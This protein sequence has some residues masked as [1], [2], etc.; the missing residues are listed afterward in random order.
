[1]API[2]IAD[3]HQTFP[4]S[5][6][7]LERLS[8]T[9]EFDYPDPYNARELNIRLRPPLPPYTPA[10]IIAVGLIGRIYLRVID[11]H[12]D[13]SL[14]SFDSLDNALETA[15][16][17]DTADKSIELMLS[18]FPTTPAHYTPEISKEYRLTFT[19]SSAKRHSLYKSILLIFLADLNQ[20]LR[21]R[22]NLFTD[23]DLRNNP[24]YIPFRDVIFSHLSQG[25]PLGSSAKSLIDFLA[26][27]SRLHPDSLYD[28]L[29][30]IR[31]NWGAYLGEAFLLG[32]LKALDQIKEEMSRNFAG[33]SGPEDPL[34]YALASYRSETDFVR[35]SDDLDWMPKVI[36]IAKNVF[37][38]LDQLSKE[39][40]MPIHKLDQIPD[41]ELARLSSW[42]ITGLWL[43]GLWQ[44]SSA[45]QKIKQIRG[46]L[47]AVPSAYSL[48]DYAIADALGGDSAYQDLS[49]R[50][51]RY[52]IRLAADM[53]PNHMGIY[54]K[55]VV[56]HPDWFLSVDSS[57]YPGYSF[58]GPD[59]S[60]DDRVGIFLEDHYYNETD[61]AVVFRRLDRQTGSESFIYHGN[62]GTS[63]PWNDTAQLDFL[64]P[65]VREAV[66]QNILHVARKFPII[67]FDAAMTLAK[68][69]IQ[70]LWFPEPGSGGA[71]PT[72]SGFGLSRKFF[73]ELMP[74]EF[75]RE[76]VD[77]V[78]IEAPD[79]LLLAEAFWMMEGFF[80]RSLGMHRVYNSAFMHML[81]DEEND[82]YRDLIIKTLEYDP[83]ILKRY[84]NFMNNPDEDTAISQYGSDGKYF[85]VCTLMA[86]LPGLPMIGHGQIE[87]FSEKYGMEYQRAYYDEQP[88]Q[89]LIERHQREIFPLL[90]KRYLFAEV[91]DFYLFDFITDEGEINQNV[92]AYTNRSGEE[93]A[94]VVYHN[95][96]ADTSGSIQ[97]SATVNGSSVSLIDSLGITRTAG[98]YLLFRDHIS[99]LEFIRNIDD[100]VSGGIRVELGAYHYMVFMDF[101][102]VEDG[103]GS[104]SA[105]FEFLAG[106]GT[107]S[108]EFSR[109][110]LKLAPVSSTIDS[111]YTTINSLL[112]EKADSK[113]KY[114]KNLI[115][116]L[117]ELEVV[118]PRITKGETT[119]PANFE[120]LVLD[121]ITSLVGSSLFHLIADDPSSKVTS[122]LWVIL[123]DVYLSPSPGDIIYTPRSLVNQ[124]NIK[125]IHNP[126]D[127][128]RVPALAE[129]CASL[130]V[131]FMGSV[132]EL[133]DLACI[134]LDSEISDTYLGVN[135]Y[136][137][138]TW[139]NKES[140][141]DLL[142]M[143]ILILS[144]IDIQEKITFGAKDRLSQLTKFRNG[145]LK[146]LDESDYNL[147]AFRSLLKKFDKEWNS[148]LAS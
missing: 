125:S 106:K 58:Q 99:G 116:L 142:D 60:E 113:S 104:Y 77:R 124:A 28:Q 111:I 2:K 63:M 11:L 50:A 6:F 81:R 143:T 13:S 74:E 75:W 120:S 49:R 27:P 29:E 141:E 137:G 36:L 86:T 20:A 96:W 133:D 128:S 68:K 61:A 48:Y 46:N 18:H 33:K 130:S 100:F 55:W 8:L 95:K 80:V 121:R 57:P 135:E 108:L 123:A 44:R 12:L 114:K 14:D 66:I 25:P 94:L 107:P 16:G 144:T 5:R 59:L 38:W 132:L 91:D 85:G 145:I 56:E 1:M 34:G 140:F 72:R 129:I 24:G 35:F 103:D 4:L 71:I 15:L 32:L 51:G 21:S 53:V 62:D 42:G 37:V 82:K 109:I 134:W 101:L 9:P 110:D 97:H 26:E 47:D 3:A 22:D 87:G 90:H 70:R 118:L 19:E 117:K 41:Q 126:Q 115:P 131:K 23:S 76:V 93:S 92:F 136:N 83:Q 7:A 146:L 105:L 10:E 52:N 73:D 65:V 43:I 102:A 78:A 98:D 39:Y 31:E 138:V 89:G 30:F 112:S 17:P 139:F 45:S 127:L 88:N 40:Q 54:S 147:D 64:N 122:I 148:Q 119:L 67:R 79:T 69:H 84:V